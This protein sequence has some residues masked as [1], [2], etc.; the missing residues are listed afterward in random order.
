MGEM[1][2]NTTRNPHERDEGKGNR[3]QASFRGMN[4][5]EGVMR[6]RLSA[7]T[8]TLNQNSVPSV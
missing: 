7:I 6:G 3:V 5:A 8:V 1:R 2:R 4:A